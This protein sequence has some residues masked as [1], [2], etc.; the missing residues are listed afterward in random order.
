MCGI[1]GFIDF[2]NKSDINTLHNMLNTIDH[3]GPD[4]TGSEFYEQNNVQVALGHK[5]LAIL[6]LSKKGH[7]PYKYENLTM[8]YNG[9]VYNFKDI[10]KELEILGY[11]F[12][13]NSD[14]EVIIKAYH[15]WGEEAVHKFN[16][17]FA[18]SIYNDEERTL[19][20]IRDRAGVK[21]LYYYFKDNLFMFSSELKAFHQ[22]I[23]FDKEL[24]KNSLGLYL[25]FGYVPQPKSIFKNAN[26]LENGYI[27]KFDI[28]QKRFNKQQYWN[29]YDFYQSKKLELS[30]DEALGKLDELVNSSIKYRMIS[31]VPL[32][33]FLS[34]GYDSSLVTAVMQS[35]SNRKVKTFTI[36]FENKRYDESPHAKAVS[37]YLGTEH[38][39]Y[40]C[41]SKDALE[42]LPKLPDI[43]DEPMSDT[44]IIPTL[45]VSMITKQNVTV[46]LSADGGDELFGGYNAYRD[47]IRLNGKFQ[48]IPMKQALSSLLKGF[49]GVVPNGFDKLSR[50]LNR[51]SNMLMAENEAQLHNALSN[52]FIPNDIK[53]LLITE[54]KID[55]KNLEVYRSTALTNNALD[56]LLA[57][58]FQSSHVDQLLVK[59]DRATMFYSLEGRE[60]LLDYRLIEFAAKLPDELKLKRDSGKYLLKKLTHKY[61]PKEIMDRPKMG[62]S[63][64]INDWFKSSFNELVKHYF[65]DNFL[66]E[67]NIFNLEE[68]RRIRNN[69]FNG[70]NVNLR[71]LWLILVFQ[72]WYERWN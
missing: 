7:Q 65:D 64:P 48:Q 54:P 41:T 59:V 50:R 70:K 9:E 61:I 23:D 37:D 32:G 6:D 8:V 63:V 12:E 40:I 66:K 25:Q 11:T 30:E 58:D 16:G 27:L 39:E 47:A 43:L 51:V 60:P 38:T 36:G 3:R 53:K 4:D 29:I 10:K 67:Q 71:Q 62:F 17:M 2:R 5:R 42:L 68:L 46:S 56:S 13:S 20:L 24:D 72:I 15:Q 35:N 33:S 1:V 26:K 55:K 49:S 57:K 44:S 28:D 31:D 22:H 69:Y 19:T 45:I 52:V 21:P 34:G 18:I 14:T